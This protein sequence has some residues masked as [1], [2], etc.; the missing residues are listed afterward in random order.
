MQLL[1]ALPRPRRFAARKAPHA[2][3]GTPKPLELTRVT[4]VRARE[5]GDA[6]AAREWLSQLRRDP[7]RRE[8]FAFEGLAQLNRVLH[9]QRVATMDPYL[10]ELGLGRVSAIRVGFGTGDQLAEGAWS[11]AVE[12]AIRDPRARRANAIR[13]QERV[14]A[15]LGGRDEVRACETLL[16]RARLDLD[17]GRPR[18]AALQLQVGLEALLAELGPAPDEPSPHPDQARDLDALGSRRDRIQAAARTACQGDLSLEQAELITEA[19]AL[20][21]RVLR[22][23]RILG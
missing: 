19:L 3:P 8:T 2:E 5:L 16:L 20:C 4:A 15:V 17:E 22:R 14:A 23:R 13:P 11:E 6:K 7:Q 18:E 9:A 1:G 10:A 12:V 21:E